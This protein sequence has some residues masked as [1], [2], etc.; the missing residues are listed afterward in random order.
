[1]RSKLISH[2]SSHRH[3]EGQT[4]GQTDRRADGQTGRRADGQTG[5][6][7]GSEPTNSRIARR[8]SKCSATTPRF[9][10][11]LGKRE[12]ETSE[13][14]SNNSW[15]R[16]TGIVWLNSGYRSWLDDE[17]A[18]D[19][20][21]SIALSCPTIS[22]PSDKLKL[23]QWRIIVTTTRSG[24]GSRFKTVPYNRMT[25]GRISN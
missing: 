12:D 1:M 15:M 14:D 20:K 5:R 7:T 23:S 10:S 13:V 18:E 8:H 6:Q 2:C 24:S 3:T 11:I 22:E 9:I 21:T 4:D 19:W 25:I 17:N 16:Q